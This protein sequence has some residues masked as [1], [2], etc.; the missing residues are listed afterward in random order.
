ME[1]LKFTISGRG[2]SFTR[3][4][5]NTIISSYSHI[6]KVSIL[7]LLGAII[8]FDRKDNP[9]DSLPTFYSKLKD[10][11]VA[12]VPHN[13]KFISSVDY[14]IEHTGFSN[15][16][17]S[18]VG[19]YE[20][21]INPS[22]DI[23]IICQTDNE[24]FDNIKEFILSGKA[25]FQP[26]LGRNHWFANISNA[27]ILE[28]KLEFIKDVSIDSLYDSTYV[29]TI[30]N[31][32]FMIE[33]ISFKEFMPVGI[34]KRLKQ[35]NEHQLCFSNDLIENSEVELLSCDNKVLYLI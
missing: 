15:D 10:L 16:G 33:R 17:S 1:V 6:H 11:K 21:L 13:Y 34:D 9:V 3:P 14:M 12:I 27:E 31:E 25:I 24:H 29:T 19:K 5:F 18:F 28:G 23:Y 32:D 30:E 35:Y 22:W 2:A 7:G 4:H 26:Y 8:G 20:N